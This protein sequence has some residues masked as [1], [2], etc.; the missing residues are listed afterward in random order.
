MII[1]ANNSGKTS[2]MRPLLLMKQTM[3]S[4]DTRLALKT[5][6]PLV[7]VGR[8]SDMVYGH[9][10]NR[11]IRFGLRFNASEEQ[12]NLNKLKPIGTYPPGEI[13]IELKGGRGPLEVTLSR[14]SLKDIRG[15]TCLVRSLLSN[16]KY[17]LN[18]GRKLDAKFFKFA[19]ASKP[20][21][22]LFPSHGLLQQ[23][24]E[25]AEK[26]AERKKKRQKGKA[27]RLALTLSGESMSYFNFLH[28]TETELNQLFSRLSYIG[29][30]REYPRR[31]YESK[32]EI[33]ATVGLRGED[34]PHILFLKRDKTFHRNVDQWLRNLGLARKVSCAPLHEGLFGVRTWEQITKTEIDFAD[35]GFGL[36]Q[37]L[38][39]VVQG[40]HAKEESIIFLEQPEI[41]LNPRLQSQLPDL[42]A[43]IVESKR[44]VVVE[45]H[46][47]HLVLRLR[48]LIAQGKLKPEDTALYY[49]E[50]EKGRSSV[51]RIPIAKDGHIE[52]LQWPKGFFEDSL[53]EALRLARVQDNRQGTK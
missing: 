13:S 21:H 12:K 33:P 5:T 4:R 35:T 24:L 38:P 1:G 39:L 20:V 46:S 47:E 17:S 6:G 32:E 2:L 50:K 30:L 40:F 31:Y 19:T 3:D 23:I 25:S 29:P 14:L 53:G 48:T 37:L 36:S 51:R 16:G 10:S 18:F 34:A 49:V 9:K 52:S 43:A 41:H 45:T 7:D 44:T 26:K 22:F 11:S 15:R 8:F 28:F 42:F 27:V